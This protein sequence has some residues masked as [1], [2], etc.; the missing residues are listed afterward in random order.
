MDKEAMTDN[1]CDLWQT[2]FLYVSGLKE[3]LSWFRKRSDTNLN[4]NLQKMA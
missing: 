4:L 3:N 1:K 2:V